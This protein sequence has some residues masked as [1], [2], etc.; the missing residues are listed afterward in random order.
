MAVKKREIRSEAVQMA[1]GT[2]W[3][4]WIVLLD[5][6]GARKMTHQEIVAVVRDKF[7][8]RPW[9]QQMVTVGYEQARGLRARHQKPEGFQISRSKTVSAPISRLYAAF[10]EPSAQALWLGQ[11]VAA[12]ITPRTCHLDK[13]AR[14]LWTDG[15]TTVDALFYEKGEDKSQV[16]LQH[17][18]L[19]S[20]EE[21]AAMKAYWGER[22]DALKLLLEA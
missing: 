9:W 14:L 10:A 22:L 19:G 16:A 2:T 3:D 4:E 18:K 21:A 6:A 5:R 17:S 20:A 7:K 8:I 11:D 15:R 13:S 1:T 12:R